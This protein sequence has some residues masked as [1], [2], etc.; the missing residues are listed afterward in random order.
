VSYRRTRRQ[1]PGKFKLRKPRWIDPYPWIDGTEPEKRVFEMLMKRGIYFIFQGQVPE[2]ERGGSKEFLAPVGYK[3]DFVLPEYRLI[4]DPFSPF[5]HSKEDAAK[6]DVNK[7]AVYSAAGYAYYH[8]WA[9]APGVWTWDQR[10]QDKSKE[11]VGRDKKGKVV[12]KVK[13]YQGVNADKNNYRNVNRSLVGQ[14]DTL[15]MLQSIP[16]LGQGPHYPLTDARDVAA[17]R[18]KGYRIGEFL[19]A[20]ANS[21]AAANHKRKHMKS[22]GVTVGTRRSVRR[23][24]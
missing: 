18:E 20:G 14:M 8:P 5:H 21:V 12:F 10:Y 23:A 15:Q 7:V 22:L 9:T 19:G 4:I 16:E 17:K 1:T 13:L 11:I 6:R 24:R 3:P 2:F